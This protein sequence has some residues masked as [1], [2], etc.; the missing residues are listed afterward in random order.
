[1]PAALNVRASRRAPSL[2]FRSTQSAGPATDSNRWFLRIFKPLLTLEQ[3]RYDAGRAR[4][5]YDAVDPD[6][7][8]VAAELEKRWNERLRWC[9]AWRWSWRN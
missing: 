6:N 3:A 4:R 7:R 8:L 5:Q 9:A 1:M 2:L